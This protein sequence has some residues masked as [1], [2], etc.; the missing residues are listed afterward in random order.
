MDETVTRA[1]LR[2]GPRYRKSPF[3]EA[4][5]RAGC[6][7]WGIYNHMYLPDW[8][9]DPVEEYRSLTE[10]AALWDAGVQRVVEISGPDASELVNRLTPRDLTRCAVGQGRYAPLTAED[11]G[12]V[13]EPVALRLGENRWWLSL[14]DSDAGLWARGY[15]AGSGL[16]ARVREPEIYPLQLQG[17]KSPAVMAALFGEAALRLGYYRTMETA[18]DGIPVVV[19]RTGWTG[20]LG[21]E[22]YLCDP[23][24]GGALWD[25]VMEAGAAHGIRAIAPSQIRRVEAGIFRYGADLTIENNPFEVTG[26]ERLVEDQSADYLGKTALMRIRA[27]GVRRK[28]VG[29]ALDAAAPVSAA[30]DA[31]PARLDGREIGKVTSLVWSPRLGRNVG[32]VW[33]PA[34]LAAPGNRIEVDTLDGSFPAATAPLPFVDPGKKIPTAPLAGG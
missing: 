28:L 17:P 22:I 21:F 32:Y 5:R 1:E 9:G 29:V 2:F 23:A 31:A 34:A 11:G 13:N 18:L 7:S 10:D 8:Y 24:R 33:V 15:A 4:T 12:I 16:D 20:E 27:E 6:R 14:S 25:R 30:P 19:S 26:L 3:F